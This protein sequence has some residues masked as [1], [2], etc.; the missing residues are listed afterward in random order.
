MIN[1]DLSVHTGLTQL[2]IIADNYKTGKWV[3]F[4]KWLQRL[5]QEKK[6]TRSNRR[7]AKAYM[8]GLLQ[9]QGTVQGFLV[10]DIDLKKIDT[11]RR[12]WPFFRDRRIDSYKNI[13]KNPR[14]D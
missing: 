13:L 1:Y 9:T 8:R 11:I 10:C 12:H 14:D 4:A 6:W 3:S 7:N 2:R 5:E